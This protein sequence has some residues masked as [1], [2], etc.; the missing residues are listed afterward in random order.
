[1]V[2]KICSSYK[3][4]FRR[5]KSEV[6]YVGK[7]IDNWQGDGLISEDSATT[8]VATEKNVERRSGAKLAGF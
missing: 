8:S 3:K 6:K 5:G 4:I 1:M 2:L 7:R